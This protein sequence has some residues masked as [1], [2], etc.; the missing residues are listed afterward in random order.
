M[1]DGQEDL[2]LDGAYEPP[3]ELDPN[4]PLDDTIALAVPPLV[5]GQLVTLV[6][7]G[8]RAQSRTFFLYSLAGPGPYVTTYGFTLDLT[9]PIEN[10]G[11]VKATQ[12][13]SVGLAATVPSTAPVGLPVWVQAVEA[14]GNPAIS[15]RVSNLVATA[16]Q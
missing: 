3:A 16:V 9:P 15:F 11:A 7:D 10:L 8:V 2:D 14:W 6:A 13:G 1:P 12:A 4:D 5:R